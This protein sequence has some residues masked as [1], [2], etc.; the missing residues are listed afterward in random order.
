V[1]PD[2]NNTSGGP[3]RGKR[4]RKVDGRRLRSARTKQR[5]IEGF[6]SLLEEGHRQP[7]VVQIA[8]RSGCATR[9]IHERFRTVGEL[10]AAAADYAMAQAIALAPLRDADGDRSARIRSQVETRARTCERYLNLWR[11]LVAG[12]RASSELHSRV[13][14]ARNLLLQ[15]LEQMYSPELSRL[16]PVER[17]Q[18]LLALEALTDFE[19]WAL[20]REHHHLSFPEACA[21]W[22]AV[23]DRMLPHPS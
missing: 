4:A 7:G 9:S 21:V 2:G 19:S 20:L 17:R 16:P 1:C 15:R 13:V 18:V 8:K 22:M 14:L 12:Q 10:Q 6:L 5:I 23:I 3:D 11:L